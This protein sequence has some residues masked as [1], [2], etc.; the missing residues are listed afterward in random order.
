MLCEATAFCTVESLES[1]DGRVSELLA[2][3]SRENSV[4]KLRVAQTALE[5]AAHDSNEGVKDDAAVAEALQLSQQL[6][7]LATARQQLKKEVEVEAEL[8]RK[9]VGDRRLIEIRRRQEKIGK[10]EKATEQFTHA[11]E[12]RRLQLFIQRRAN[13]I[14]LL[15]GE[16]ASLTQ[17]VD[18]VTVYA[19]DSATASVS[20]LDDVSEAAKLDLGITFDVPL[21]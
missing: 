19:T 2:T 15:E 8:N 7:R 13:E 4:L 20:Q 18:L 9:L 3:R 16:L 6:D 17:R 1:L 11:D 14:S 10:D 5:L 12:L 21:F